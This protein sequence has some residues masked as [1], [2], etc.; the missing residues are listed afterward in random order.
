MTKTYRTTS[1]EA[2]CILAGMTPIITKLQEVVQHYNIKE[3]SSNR[4][5][6]LDYDEELKHWP[7]PADAVT[8]EEVVGNEDASVY[9]FT[10]GS[11][12]DQGVGSGAVIF[13]G[14]EMLTKLKLKLDNRSYTNQAEQLV[15]LKDLDAIESLNTHSINSRMATIFTDSRVSF[16]SLHNPNN[17]SFLVEQIRKKAASSEGSEWKIMFTWINAHVGIHGNELADRLAKEAARNDG[18]SCDFDRNPKSTLHLEAEEEAK[19]K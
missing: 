17:H 8:I 6:E 5:F 10:E 2:L 18:T 19:Q 16:D 9:A 12:H 15:I 3:K 14:R 7:H 11:K 1:S 4:T 13:K